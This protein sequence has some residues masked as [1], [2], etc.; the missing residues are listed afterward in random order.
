MVT[1]PS[2][3]PSLFPSHFLTPGS[4]SVD[5]FFSLLDLRIF[6]QIYSDKAAYL[7][8]LSCHFLVLVFLLQS[9]PSYSIV[10]I[11]IIITAI[12]SILLP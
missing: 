8:L 1:S 2:L 5:L 4:I 11:S 6:L 10:I 7:R 3:F 12:I 9:V